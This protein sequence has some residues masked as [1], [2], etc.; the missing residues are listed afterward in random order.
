MF[1]N[2]TNFNYQ[3][4]PKE[5]IGFY[6]TYAFS[7][8]VLLLFFGGAYGIIGVM[9]GYGEE[10]ITLMSGLG[11][12]MIEIVLCIFFAIFF[13]KKK[14]LSNIA[15]VVFTAIFLA[16]F[17]IFFGFLLMLIP[18]AYLTT[19]PSKKLAERDERRNFLTKKDKI[20]IWLTALGIILISLI[21]LRIADYLES[22]LIY[23][24]YMYIWN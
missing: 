6:I 1:S 3:R 20:L 23:Q 24:E 9:Y 5:A 11:M 7:A 22:I 8:M 2:L 17:G 14:N 16:I 18:Y 12:N 4:S 19:I 21:L 13:F 10:R 15:G